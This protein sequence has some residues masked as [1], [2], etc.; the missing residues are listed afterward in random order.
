VSRRTIFLFT[1]LS[2]ASAT[3]QVN[4]PP[5][6]APAP[7]PGLSTRAN[8]EPVRL[9]FP[10]TDVREVL[11]FYERLTGK[12]IVT[13]NQVQGTVYIVVPGEIPP[14]EAIRIIEI[15][16][17]LNGFTMIPAEGSDIVKVVG[18]NKNPRNAAIPIIADELLLPAGEQVVTFI[19]KLQYADATELQQTLTGYIGQAQGGYTNITALPK[20]Q[21]PSGDCCASS[22]RSTCR[23]RK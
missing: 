18:A 7:I 22:T 23:R 13:D 15:N 17:Q 5:R 21:T 14:D 20:A 11:D 10:N 9:Q 3:A 12:R 6:N 4:V 8:S 1:L 19:A 16:L 2:V